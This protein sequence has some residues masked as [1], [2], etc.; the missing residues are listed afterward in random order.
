ME[1]IRHSDRNKAAHDLIRR[2]LHQARTEA[3]MSQTAI[4]EKLGLSRNQYWKYETGAARLYACDIP[5]FAVLFGKPVS[6]FFQD[7]SADVAKADVH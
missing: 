3:R 7:V 5:T 4:A 1:S 6:W 2:R